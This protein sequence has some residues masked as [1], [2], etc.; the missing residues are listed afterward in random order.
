MEE[1]S[2]VPLI[3]PQ[4][5]NSKHNYIVERVLNPLNTYIKDMEGV[6]FFTSANIVRTF[7][8]VWM[9]HMSH[10]VAE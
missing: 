8:A 1:K 4:L 2:H 5:V 6:T 7:G 9:L 10:G 3:L